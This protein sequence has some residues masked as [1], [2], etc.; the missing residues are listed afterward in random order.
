M[1]GGFQHGLRNCYR[2]SRPEIPWQSRRSS[3]EG[4]P[5]PLTKE[6][7]VPLIPDC[8]DIDVAPEFLCLSFNACGVRAR[9]LSE[10]MLALALENNE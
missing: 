4:I 6:P 3:I 1:S 7:I 9:Q 8:A 10:T 5:I 2:C